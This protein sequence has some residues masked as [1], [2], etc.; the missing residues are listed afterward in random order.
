MLAESVRDGLWQRYGKAPHGAP[1][2]WFEWN[3]G[4]ERAVT[5][6]RANGIVRGDAQLHPRDC[7]LITPTSGPPA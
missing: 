7:V 4:R 3:R 2:R 6:L 1:C 5:A